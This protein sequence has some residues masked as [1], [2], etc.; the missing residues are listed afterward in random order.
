MTIGVQY[1]I[2][3]TVKEDKQI[4]GGKIE[5]LHKRIIRMKLSVDCQ[6]DILAQNED[7]DRYWITTE[8]TVTRWNKSGKYEIRMKYSV[9]KESKYNDK[10]YEFVK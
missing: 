9:H 2:I 7:G 10:I 4:Q 3:K 5:E 1:V 8:P 6:G